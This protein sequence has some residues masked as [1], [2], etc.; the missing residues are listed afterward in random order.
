MLARISIFLLLGFLSLG[1]GCRGEVVL[2]PGTSAEGTDASDPT[3][4][5]E[6]SCTPLD[7]EAACPDIL[8]CA[9]GACYNE[10][11]GPG[12]CTAESN[13]LCP[14]D[15]M[16]VS[17]NCQSIEEASA[18]SP[19][20]VEGGCPG[21]QSC[22]RG[23]CF[24]DD[25]ITCSE[26]NLTGICPPG[27]RCT[28][29]AC[30][31][32]SGS[33]SDVIQ[34]GTCPAWET[35]VRGNC[36][37]PIAPDACSADAPTGRCPSGDIC[38]AGTCTDISRANVCGFDRTS[39][40]CGPAAACVQGYCI[41]IDSESGCSQDNPDGLCPGGA[42]C[43][44][45]MCVDEACESGGYLCEPGSFCDGEG[46]CL[47]YPCEPIHP[48]GFC[49]DSTLIC[50]SG[51][52]V[53]PSCSPDY[54]DGS[55]I[56]G[57]ACVEG[58]C[59]LMPCS[60]EVP[61]GACE[62]GFECD[63][64]TCVPGPCSLDNLQGACDETVSICHPDVGCDNFLPATCC[65][66]ALTTTLG[67]ATGTC[68][69]PPCSES[70][71]YG[72]CP[73]EQYCVEGSCELAPCSPFYPTGTC[74]IEGETCRFGQCSRT[75]CALA[76]D[77]VAYCAPDIC[78][79]SLDQCITPPCSVENQNGSCALGTTCC[80]NGLS[81][82]QG[83]DVGE[84]FVPDCSAEFPGGACPTG[85]VCAGGECSTPPCSSTY[86]QG[87]CGP[88]LA[89]D[90]G[91]CIQAA[92]SNE[93]PQGYCEDSLRCIE[94]SCQ[95]YICSDAFP[96]APCPVGTLC[97][98]GSC[99]TPA[100]SSVYPG[101]ACGA[102]EICVGGVC[103][104]QPCSTAYPSGVCAPGYTC[105]AGAC[106]PGACSAEAPTGSC[107]GNDAGRICL[108]GV[109]RD[110]VCSEYFPTGPCDGGQICD[111]SSGT[112][113]CIVPACSS[114]Y[115]GGSC[116]EENEICIGGVCI[117][118]P[119]SENVLNGQCPPSQLCCDEDLAASNG[120]TLGSCTL[121]DCGID[122]LNGRCEA[123]E[124]CCNEIY[125]AQG[126]CGVLGTCLGTPCSD[127]FP[128]G[129]CSGTDDGKICV[130]G[131]CE[132]PCSD[133]AR[134]GWCPSGFDCIDGSCA[135]A[136]AGD[137]D[138]DSISDSDEYASSLV[139]SDGDGSPDFI[140]RD[141]DNDGIPDSAE[142][143]DLDLS[144]PPVAFQDGDAL[145]DYRDAD[146]D[147]DYIP[148]G[149]EAGLVLASPQD[150]DGDGEPD[151]RDA[152][153]DNDGILD[154]CEASDNGGIC[155]NE[156][157]VAQDTLLDSDE[158][159]KAD[160]LDTD[161]D[162]DGILDAVEARENP[163]DASTLDE[164]GV[165][166]D[167]DGTPDYRDTDSDD[168]GVSDAEEDVNGDG[169]VN[170]QID[171]NGDSVLDPRSV[172]SCSNFYYDYNPGCPDAKCLLAETSRVHDDTDRDGILDGVD[173]IAQVC[174][175]ENLKPVN[176]FS[177]RFGDYS[178]TLDENFNT[179]Q[180]LSRGGEPA[181]VKFH[182]TD[183]TRGSYA[184]GG[185]LLNKAPSQEAMDT[186][187]ADPS[188]ALIEKA[189]TQSAV[190][191][192]LLE[193][194]TNV[195]SVELVINRN[196]TSFD[197]YG[198]VVSRYRIQTGSNVSVRKLRDR[199]VEALGTE[200]D[201]FSSISG[202]PTS[203]DFTLLM[204]TRYRYDNGT[205]GAVVLVGAL[206]PTGTGVDDDDSYSYR[207]RCS[208]QSN[209]S[210]RDGC[211]QSGSSCIED[212]D[213][214]LPIFHM[215]NIAG[216][217]ALAQ[218]GDD[219]AAL[220]QSDVQEYGELDVL[221][222]V[223]NSGSM[224]DAIGQV[225]AS[226][227]LFFDLLGNTEADY[228]VAQ[229]TS[230]VADPD[231]PPQSRFDD[232]SGDEATF[233]TD[234]SGSAG[235]I[236]LNGALRGGFT[237]AVAGQ[238][239]ASLTDRESF[240]SGSYNP[241]CY[242]ESR[243]PG[244][245]TSVPFEYG[246]LSAQWAGYRAG[247]L[248]VVACNSLSIDH[249][250]DVS[251]CMV[252][253]DSCVEARCGAA[254]TALGCD[255]IPEC[256]RLTQ[257]DCNAVS[258][259]SWNGETCNSSTC[260]NYG[261]AFSCE[262]DL[263]CAYFDGQCTD[264]PG[265]YCKAY[266]L[267]GESSCESDPRCEWND[268]GN[269]ALC[270]SKHCSEMRY[271]P[272]GCESDSRCSSYYANICVDR[273]VVGDRV[274]CEW[275]APTNTCESSLGY[276]CWL[277]ENQAD[278]SAL[279]P[280][281]AWSDNRCVVTP[282]DPGVICSATTQADCVSQ[283]GTLSGTSYCQWDNGENR[284]APQTKYAFRDDA[285]RVMV[286]L[287]D[288]ET[289][290][291][292]DGVN[293]FGY[294]AG[295]GIC[296]WFSAYG[297]GITNYDEDTRYTRTDSFVSYYQSRGF[298]VYA[299]VGDKADPS[300]MADSSNGGCLTTS[301]IAEA[302]QGYIDVAEATGGGWGSICADDLNPTI[303]SIVIGSIAKASPYRLEGFIDG[304]NVQPIPA[305]IK[306]VAEVC[307]VPSQ[308]PTCS[309]G[310]HMEVLA[311]SRDNGFDYDAIT[312]ALIFYGD[313]RP[314]QNGDITV[315]YRYW[316]DLNQPPEGNA[317]CPC[318]E[319]TSPA[320]SCD[321]GL[322]CG[323]VG[324]DD[325]C[326]SAGNESSCDLAPG[327]TWNSANGGECVF[328]GRCEPDPTCGGGCEEGEVCDAQTG[329]CICDQACGDACAPGQLCDGDPASA[330]CGLCLCDT[331]CAGG[332]AAGQACDSDNNSDTCGQCSCDTT[333]GGGC[334]A[335]L[336]CNSDPESA[337]C[338]FCAPPQ[339]GSC[340]SGFVCDPA[341][342][343]C[344][345]DSTCGG[346]CPTGTTCD[347]DATSET[348]GQCLC[349]STC[350]GECPTGTVC[351]SGVDSDTCG[352]C[353]VDP[354]C[355]VGG[356]CNLD[357]SDGANENTCSAMMGCR[358][359]DWNNTCVAEQCSTCNPNT[360]LCEADTV[361]CE[362]GPT[363]SY[364]PLTLSCACDPTCGLSCA[365]GL[366]CD[367]NTD[368]ASCGECVC[369][370]S[371]GGECPTGLVCD[372]NA[373]CS[374]LDQMSCSGASDSCVWESG[375][376]ECLSIFCGQC[377]VDPTCGGC[378][379]GEACNPVTGLCEPQCPECAV[380]SVCDPLTGDC[381]CDQT[382]GGST[383]PVGSTCDADINSNSCGNCVCV[384]DAP[385]DG[386]PAGQAFDDG[387][388]CGAL[389]T[390][391]PCEAASG[392]VV[393]ASSN[394]CISPTCGQCV[395]DATCG[396]DCPAGFICDPLSGLCIPDFNCGGCPPNFE[397][398]PLTG[399]CVPLGG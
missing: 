170:C 308:Y 21:G 293:S 212:S 171:G 372:S 160:Y 156:T 62:D 350:G 102:G 204:E 76:Q 289:C 371:C 109:C 99:I 383:C 317:D 172:P 97:Q 74:S 164:S 138:C 251:G 40:L 52:C 310:T 192:G 139:D 285:A 386:C 106:I 211:I 352:L 3:D 231:W 116:P 159:G 90:S 205:N 101:G 33:C 362:C 189:L 264:H 197:G 65:D 228:R 112:P 275:S 338:G 48:T 298:T 294:R 36:V 216:G 118:P 169:I 384:T 75:G 292:R 329:L 149:L 133:S 203:R 269:F 375:L 330:T 272:V 35:C 200:L 395:L 256:T 14:G 37:G 233:L 361:A 11:T 162:D 276:A 26:L 53:E 262:A 108:E 368:S 128:Y 346:G 284:C 137:A 142:A 381:I 73:A 31:Q 273:I 225:E 263:D 10:T 18:C 343:V 271:D 397:C 358:W 5:V 341:A 173:G 246:L 87:S 235:Y 181:G 305:T 281:C 353:L 226:S 309:S 61:F 155:L 151:Y 58:A 95:Q 115:I 13:G 132:D 42:L 8:Y 306:V 261:S 45:G 201:A 325:S 143:G 23:F 279:A 313:G 238:A 188:R 145:A 19:A 67:C 195:S 359:A 28:G 114:E 165:D 180:A 319:T 296:D 83:C 46:T 391:G 148:D 100:C 342:G 84:C 254:T 374:G 221:W 22:V 119:C 327:C 363:E 82:S 303:E 304:N 322:A 277:N 4:V 282:S 25:S 300:Q 336:E 166:H 20:N 6:N 140:D 34:D 184:V 104:D 125:Q 43:Q 135:L 331:S 9:A 144:T 69:A 111:A 161:S 152:D 127:A 326:S 312:N 389:A 274:E 91:V 214:Q 79:F 85:L 287:S 314:T 199:L 373:G 351:D 229:T 357:C 81:D 7:R 290:S 267:Q 78:D 126:L 121:A 299:I 223:D 385:A 302:G 247:A 113:S 103:I 316:V 250:A 194:A 392:C 94:G 147:N 367:S 222:V 255:A 378:P 399:V 286:V 333:C 332:C 110:Y 182:G 86:P 249:C 242:F 56:E 382:C 190:D 215:Q 27:H 17:G 191:A 96:N 44:N 224:G 230:Q 1:L 39:G 377:V 59:E 187:I 259:C 130:E 66:D 354:T 369:D 167:E 57:F 380:G 398:D 239:G 268:A 295:N 280:R 193:A 88:N 356:N 177:L 154:R 55:C 117:L 340:P 344:V 234:D 38:V 270:L 349:D 24:D 158:D 345:C 178:L 245:F 236:A 376:G 41:A 328:N 265:R 63:A 388:A 266:T 379:E 30:F 15:D 134:D 175:D 176:V 335:G 311:R 183:S 49:E 347:P 131:S 98:D 92:C 179:S 146:S 257:T 157:L 220:C 77:P 207:T 283:G 123:G 47:P 365:P 324:V 321:P 387:S 129:S 288:E 68:T 124:I 390:G 260:S 213:Y 232:P 248:P 315:S 243:L 196:F 360:G 150:T 334:D 80:D 339:C 206:T 54:P 278:C 208:E 210:S 366:Y 364:D 337:G 252:Q 217:G 153:S 244:A 50:E 163:A 227:Q 301:T 122:N 218:F 394:T 237:G 70:E 174:A 258:S 291:L 297:L 355:G 136:C 93:A 141:S 318:P 168:D 60:A 12:A 396:G 105:M 71:P 16:C 307:D 186:V 29:G 209:C 393:D 202:G 2:P 107:S 64:G 241:A 348:C 185:F 89:C 32:D 51:V 120:C 72:A 253:E 370:T 240:C 219:V 320:C 323:L 198:V